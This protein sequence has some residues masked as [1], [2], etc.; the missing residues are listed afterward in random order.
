MGF[1]YCRYC[2]LII[3]TQTQL[4]HLKTIVLS[5]D[6]LHEYFKT[7]SIFGTNVRGT[8]G[9]EITALYHLEMK[10]GV[11]TGE[12]SHRC[13]RCGKEENIL[14]RGKFSGKMYE[15]L[16]EECYKPEREK[17]FRELFWEDKTTKKRR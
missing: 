1:N 6:I 4:K 12:Y 16:C 3:F 2:G 8:R 15:L 11:P 17:I 7:S 9:E 13:T 5:S 14:T 10:D